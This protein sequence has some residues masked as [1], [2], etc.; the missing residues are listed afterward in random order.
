[1][2]G[3]RARRGSSACVRAPR[4]SPPGPG[5]RIGRPVPARSGPTPWCSPWTTA[6]SPPAP[7][8]PPSPAGRPAPRSRPA[9]R[10]GASASSSA[11]VPGAGCR[12]GGSPPPGHGWRRPTCPGDHR[13]RPVGLPSA[14]NLRRRFH[15]APHTTPA[16]CRP[17]FPRRRG[18]VGPP[19]FAAGPSRPGSA[20]VLPHP[21]DG[22]EPA[23][24]VSCRSGRIRERGLVHGVSPG[25]PGPRGRIARRRRETTRW[26]HLPCPKGYGGAV[27]GHASPARSARRPRSGST[28]SRTGTMCQ[29]RLTHG[30]A[31]I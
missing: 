2:P 7:G 22:S 31:S 11:S 27:P 8:R 18:Q 5:G 14:V 4:C 24:G 23:L 16:A 21:P 15:E 26:G 28:G 25:P 20:A 19:G 17:A 1:V 30:E 13:A 9:R 12:S 10:P 29:S 3:T 6:P